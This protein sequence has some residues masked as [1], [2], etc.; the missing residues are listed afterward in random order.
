MQNRLEIGANR[1][2]PSNEAGKSLATDRNIPITASWNQM[3]GTLLFRNYIGDD[4][5]QIENKYAAFCRKIVYYVQ[6]K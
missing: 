3:V 2:T 5:D 6:L 4:L 1:E